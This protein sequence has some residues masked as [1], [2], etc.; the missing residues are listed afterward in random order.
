M[1]HHSHKSQAPLPDTLKD[2]V[3]TAQAR[4]DA[5]RRARFEQRGPDAT[6]T[7][8]QATAGRAAMDRTLSAGAREAEEAAIRRAAAEIAAAAFAAGEAARRQ[9]EQEQAAQ[10]AAGEAACRQRDQEQA[11][12]F[13]A[14]VASQQA[15]QL[16]AQMAAPMS[17]TQQFNALFEHEVTQRQVQRLSGQLTAAQVQEQVRAWVNGE[18]SGCR[19]YEKPVSLFIGGSVVAND[20][21][22][23][24]CRQ[25]WIASHQH[26][27][28]WFFC[29]CFKCDATDKR[30]QMIEMAC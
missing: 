18:K 2:V 20:G 11:A 13:A 23:R 29:R 8:P 27:D 1:L 15:A 14:H 30:N 17:P 21:A 4:L 19:V 25:R 22:H 7:S 3:K 24:R 28:K 10:F 12:Q 26:P 6:P 5:Y 9:R 16:A